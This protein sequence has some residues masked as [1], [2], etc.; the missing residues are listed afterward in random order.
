MNASWKNFDENY[1]FCLISFVFQCFSH[2]IR[3]LIWSDRLINEMIKATIENHTTNIKL[4]KTNSFMMHEIPNHVKSV[5][6]LKSNEF[7]IEFFQ[8]DLQKE[9]NDM[10]SWISLLSR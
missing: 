1:F 2:M 8:R 9:L 5:A 6:N 7:R 4:I 3:D 10:S